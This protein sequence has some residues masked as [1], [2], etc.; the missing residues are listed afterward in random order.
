MPNPGTAMRLPFFILSRKLSPSSAKPYAQS[1]LV[2]CAVEASII[3]TSG[4]SQRATASLAAA[5][6]RQRKVISE[7]FMNFFLSS[8]SLRFC[9]LISSISMSLR[10]EN[11]SKILKWD[12]VVFLRRSLF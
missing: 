3:L 9:S 10:P 8:G 4:L 6:G 7:A 2:L 11:L 5:S 12:S 1:G